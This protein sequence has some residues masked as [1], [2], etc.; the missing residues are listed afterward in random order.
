METYGKNCLTFIL[1][2][3]KELFLQNKQVARA[4]NLY[5]KDLCKRQMQTTKRVDIWTS[6]NC[7]NCNPHSNQEHNGYKYG[8][9][10]Q[11]TQL[12]YYQER[13]TLMCSIKDVESIGYQKMENQNQSRVQMTKIVSSAR[14]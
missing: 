13:L 8:D 11:N 3:I 9:P 1:E 5:V 10:Q 4:T 6:Q 2:E 14:L 12:E 7:N